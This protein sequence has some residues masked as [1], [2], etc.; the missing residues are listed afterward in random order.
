[1]VKGLSPEWWILQVSSA[2]DIKN[3][4]NLHLIDGTHELFNE[5]TSVYLFHNSDILIIFIKLSDL[6]VV[7]IIK[8]RKKDFIAV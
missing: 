6:S 4:V 1:M 8:L 5:Y 2:T 3:E 7:V